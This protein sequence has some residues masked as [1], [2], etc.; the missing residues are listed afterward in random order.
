MKEQKQEQQTGLYALIDG[1]NKKVYIGSRGGK[2]VM[3]M[4]DGKKK[5][6]YLKSGQC[7]V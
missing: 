3:V 7:K 6:R 4:H 1:G 5:K 2:Y